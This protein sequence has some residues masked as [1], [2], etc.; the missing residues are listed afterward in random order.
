MEHQQQAEPNPLVDP[1]EHIKKQIEDLNR[2]RPLK[3]FTP[4]GEII[5][6]RQDG[7]ERELPYAVEEL[8]DLPN[9]FDLK[10]SLYMDIMARLYE[11]CCQIDKMKK[12]RLPLTRA[13]FLNP[14][15]IGYR[16]KKRDL[17]KLIKWGL[18]SE[19]VVDVTKDEEPKGKRAIVY[20]TPK[21]RAFVRRYFEPSYCIPPEEDSDK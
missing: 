17:S 18:V 7:V 14:A 9:G 13:E 1:E 19:N 11:S 20:F 8:G 6:Q 12:R 16:V 21:G 2:K 10:S 15:V 5:V 3:K 4:H